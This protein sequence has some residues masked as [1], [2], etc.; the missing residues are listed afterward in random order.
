[1]P[2]HARRAGCAVP[3]ATATAHCC[4]SINHEHAARGRP[5][6]RGRSPRGCVDLRG[7]CWGQTDQPRPH[8]RLGPGVVAPSVE[9]TSWSLCWKR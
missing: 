8:E 5:R 4:T 6:N 1:M 7:C 2:A 3:T 9:R